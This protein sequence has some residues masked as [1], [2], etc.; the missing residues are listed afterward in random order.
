VAVHCSAD[1]VVWVLVLSFTALVVEQHNQVGN[2]K[3]TGVGESHSDGLGSCV[4]CVDSMGWVWLYY[5]WI[6]DSIGVHCI[7]I[8]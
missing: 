1:A 4:L 3:R 7:W 6:V 8:V 2:V 5:V